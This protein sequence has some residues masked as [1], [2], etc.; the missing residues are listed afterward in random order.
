MGRAKL[1]WPMLS[2]F[3]GLKLLFRRSLP[4][5]MCALVLAGCSN[6]APAPG[7]AAFDAANKLINVNTD[8]VAFGDTPDS[9]AMAARFADSIKRMQRQMFSG[10][11]GRSLATGGE[12]VTYVRCTDQAVVVLCHV[13]ELRNYKEPSVRESL[14]NVAWINAQMA[15]RSHPGATPAH[16]LVVGLRGFASYGPIWEGPLEGDAVKKTDSGLERDRL[17]PFFMTET[18]KTEPAVAAPEL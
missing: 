15:A 13:P 9:Q 4:A 2:L 3:V 1:S 8:G 16:K 10:G 14:A 5:L 18:V 12:F 7:K 17:Y 11:S 6:E